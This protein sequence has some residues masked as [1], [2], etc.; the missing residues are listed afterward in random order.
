MAERFQV[1]A[2]HDADD[3]V[4]D[5]DYVPSAE[6]DFRRKCLEVWCAWLVL[7]PYALEVFAQVDVLSGRIYRVIAGA[8]GWEHEP[9]LVPAYRGLLLQVR[10]RLRFD[11]RL[12]EGLATCDPMFRAA[13]SSRCLLPAAADAIVSRRG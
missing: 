2:A 9:A 5:Y 4:W 7:N 3:R 1:S 8:E 12:C 13:L 10:T 11:R 6:R